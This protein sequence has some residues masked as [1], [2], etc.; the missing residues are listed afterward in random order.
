[1][2][3]L[4]NLFVIITAIIHRP[5]RAV[6]NLV[7]ANTCFG[8]ILLGIMSCVVITKIIE[9]DKI[10]SIE[11]YPLQP[12]S[13]CNVRTY[14]Q[15]WTAFSVYHSFAV[16]SLS[17]SLFLQFSKKYKQF[18]QSLTFH[19]LLI[20][21]QWII[22]TILLLPF[23]LNKNLIVYDYSTYTYICSFPF[24]DLF[25][26]I[27]TTC[28]CFIIPCIIIN[29]IYYT[30]LRHINKCSK[31]QRRPHRI[32]REKQRHIRLM[33]LLTVFSAAGCASLIFSLLEI[34]NIRNPAPS[35]ANRLLAVL[36]SV[37]FLS[38]SVARLLMNEELKQIIKNIVTIRRQNKVSTAVV[39][40]PLQ[41]RTET[42]F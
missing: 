35:Y 7:I 1:M 36:S 5:S 9:A 32:K 42:K 37:T 38:Y 41:R 14:L 16:Q 12:D 34:T 39:V 17:R 6:A 29:T 4:C 25:A 10:P 2:G 20:G 19:L 3:L 27:Y 8:S 28:V 18:L 33:I 13:C 11:D 22:T 31:A 23:L 21:V 26:I 40:E 24:N 30:N 15:L